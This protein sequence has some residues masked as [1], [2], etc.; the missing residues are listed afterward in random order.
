MQLSTEKTTQRLVKSIKMVGYF[1]KAWNLDDAADTFRAHHKFE[2]W[3][4]QS[5]AELIIHELLPLVAPSQPL[6]IRQAALEGVCL[7]C[8]SWPE[9][10]LRKE[11]TDTLQ[12]A[13]QTHDSN[14][15]LI[16]M[17][18]LGDFLRIGETQ[19]KAAPV[20]N[21][22]THKDP[23]QPQLGASMVLSDADHAATLLAQQFFNDV[24][25]IA[26]QTNEDVAL[27]ATEL[28]CSTN[29][30][31]LVHPRYSGSVLVALE[32]SPNRAIAA[33]AYQEHLSLNSKHES[34]LEK[35][36]LKSIER[37]FVYQRDTLKNPS[38]LRRG[39]HETTAKLDLFF[40][41]LQSSGVATRKK[42]LPNLCKRL[43]INIAKLGNPQSLSDHYSFAKFVCQ[44]L[45]LASYGRVDEIM[46]VCST[47][48][49]M[50]GVTG[51]AL[52][53]LLEQILAT[54][55][56]PQLT[57]E[58]LQQLTLCSML[59]CLFWQ[60]RSHLRS[61]TTNIPA[62]G[63][64]QDKRATKDTSKAPTKSNSSDKYEE[65]F[66]RRTEAASPLQDETSMKEQCKHFMDLFSTDHE[67]KIANEDYE[68]DAE[69]NGRLTTP[70]GDAAS[71]GSGSVPPSGSSQKPRIKRRRS[72]TNS[73]AATPTGRKRGR[74]RLDQRKQS[75]TKRSDDDDGWN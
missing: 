9:N 67:A 73:A 21:G 13:I 55:S 18:G 69:I 46:L 61:V 26:L 32:T 58:R 68:S 41:V 64:K 19:N 1:G 57:P 62:S 25:Q 51:S 37:A 70:N 30:Q 15:E 56:S 5:V 14:L 17:K 10:F 22:D 24:Q 42:F 11:V 20:A 2:W 29:R 65:S 39:E 3:K 36:Y 54:E 59:L 63:A 35:E 45:A 27:L 60:T 75:T 8:L 50:F 52:S 23:S 28:I 7:T 40:R 12:E 72:E 44:N 74:P 6:E 47:L 33:A 4:G 71:M 34:I 48:E 66:I 16:V 49:A 31:G 38:G 53:Q 43:D